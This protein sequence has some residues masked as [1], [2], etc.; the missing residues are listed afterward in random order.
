[1]RIGATEKALLSEDAS[2]LA[3]RIDEESKEVGVPLVVPPSIS[4]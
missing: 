4:N 1:M 2:M 3:T